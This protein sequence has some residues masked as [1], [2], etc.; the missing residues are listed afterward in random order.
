MKKYKTNKALIA[1]IGHDEIPDDVLDRIQGYQSF[2][3]TD[4]ARGD[5][6]YYV[7][8]INQI[9]QNPEDDTNDTTKGRIGELYEQIKDCS[10]L[11][12]AMVV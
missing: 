6:I 10:Y 9:L 2:N 3:D 5:E 4:G 7:E 8:R 1:R 12:I 11:R